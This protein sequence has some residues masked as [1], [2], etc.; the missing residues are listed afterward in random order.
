MI[1]LYD[2]LSNIK[3]EREALVDEKSK[4]I[5]DIRFKYFL[6][7]D[8]QCLRNEIGNVIDKINSIPILDYYFDKNKNIKYLVIFGGGHYGHLT[9]D[10]L[11]KSMYKDYLIYF[12]DN[13]TEV[14]NRLN[15]DGYRVLTAQELIRNYR[16]GVVI[17]AGYNTRLDIY[18]QLQYSGFPMDKVINPVSGIL[19][20]TCGNQYFD[21]FNSERDDEIFVDAGC[22]DGGTSIEFTKWA[23][24]YKQIIALEANKYF[25][26]RCKDN[27][28]SIDRVTILEKAAW[29]KADSLLFRD[30]SFD[31]GAR[32]DGCGSSVVAADS[33]DN[34]LQGKEATFIKMD[35]EG[36]EYKAL[37]GCE[38]TI[39]EYKPKLAISVYHKP[40]DIIEIPFIIKK[41]NPD[42][43][44][45]L[46]HYTSSSDETILY[47]F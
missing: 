9:Y 38:K 11:K 23:K 6:T 35:I 4:E 19:V 37:I 30:S 39:K 24:G 45:A 5:F 47:A 18:D 44:F 12:C 13:N 10:L 32:I 16:D 14:L 43:K 31:G 1:E 2:Y 25:V 26:K 34:I 41:Y 29:N 27:L 33:I 17:I 20:G 46:R 36:A 8:Y 22:F 7:R 15:D 28:N 3:K 42:Y 40:E 21:F